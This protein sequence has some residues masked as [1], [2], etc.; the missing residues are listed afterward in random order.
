MK[1]LFF[2]LTF[3]MLG[4]SLFA[5]KYICAE[6][7]LLT[8]TDYWPKEFGVNEQRVNVMCSSSFFSKI[9]KVSSIFPKSSEFHA[10]YKI[11]EWKIVLLFGKGSH[12]LIGNGAEFKNDEFK[13]ALEN[14]RRIKFQ[15]QLTIVNIVT[16][17]VTKLKPL[18][19]K[20]KE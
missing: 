19:F 5:Q 15:F 13:I 4:T 12:T 6:R 11:K 2:T 8:E 18:S 20:T 10:N 14:Y 7:K 16:K 9:T 3:F 1:Y 17:E